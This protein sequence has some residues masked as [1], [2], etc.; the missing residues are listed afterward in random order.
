VFVTWRLGDSLPK[1]KLDQWKEERT[2]WLSHHPEPW[3]E[4]T[5]TEYH[6]RFSRQIDEWLDQGSG[7]CVLKDPANAK[8]V[9]NALRHF[10]GNRYEIASFVVM[11]NHVHV[12]FRP[13]GEHA[14]AEIL[15]SWKGFTAREI[16]KRIGKSG[17]LW[18][19]EY[20]DRLIRNERHFFRVAEYIRQNPVKA[21]LRE[22]HFILEE[23]RADILVR[24]SADKGGLENPPVSGSTKLRDQPCSVSR[25]NL[26]LTVAHLRQSVSSHSLDD[27]GKVAIGLKSQHGEEN[28]SQPFR[29]R[30]KFPPYAH[31]RTDLVAGGNLPATPHCCGRKRE[32]GRLAQKA[33]VETAARAR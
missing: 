12:L 32:P 9:A 30:R 1:A 3:D 26:V 8:V 31:L 21:K 10:D 28:R 11:P 15:K 27:P 14:L 5:E 13:L 22:G 29:F 20:W 4:K 33:H 17:A 25:K 19:D 23:R 2:I 7:S 18:Q 24:H 16:N 6:D